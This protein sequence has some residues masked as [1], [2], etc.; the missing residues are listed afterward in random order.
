MNDKEN[1][2]RS[3]NETSTR[4]GMGA[5]RPSRRIV[6]GH[7]RP[8]AE[9][10]LVD[11]KLD[12][13]RGEVSCNSCGLVVEENVIDPGAEWTNHANTGV[14]RSRVGAPITHTL[15]DKGL[16]T[17][18]AAS[19]LTSGGASR[20]GISARSRR[21]WRR[22]RVIDERSKTRQSK[23]RNR[24]KAFQYIRDRSQLPSSLK[25]EA[26]RIYGMLS[27]EGF[28][29]GRSIAGVT[30]ACTYLVARKEGI[31]RQIP[32]LAEKFHVGEKELSRLIRGVSRRFNMHTITLPPQFF[33]K[34][35]S[36]LELPPE[37]MMALDGLWN[38]IEPHTDI[39]QG[40][41]PMGVAAAL[42]YKA[43]AEG[44]TRRTQS[45]ICKVANVSEVTLRG[46]IKQIDGLLKS[47]GSPSA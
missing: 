19:D 46:L 18:I 28:V 33:P 32:D 41:K 23:I 37:T 24:V 25:E 16:N 26:C 11:W 35:V 30:A 6:A 43:A 38:T 13:S 14:D 10:G 1:R 5:S 31:P 20:N 17:S 42:I 40:K 29:T 3:R 44:G 2:S 45:D 7:T 22:R 21:E 34:F 9:C 12:D 27:D 47:I 15:A 8:C 36:D 4:T 39:W